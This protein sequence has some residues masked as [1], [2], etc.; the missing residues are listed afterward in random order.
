MSRSRRQ[1]TAG[2]AAGPGGAVA[3]PEGAG[4]PAAARAGAAEAAPRAYGQYCGL[5]RAVELVGDRWAMLILRDLFVGPRRYSDLHNGLPRIPTNVL[6]ARLKA[7][8]AGGVVRR[9]L[10][11]RPA[12]GVVYELTEYGAALEDVVLGLG[13]W[14]AKSLGEIRPGEVVTPDSLVMALRSTFRPAAARGQPTGYE[15]RVGEVTVH[16]RVDDGTVRVAAGPLPDADLTIEAGP[17]IRALMAG[18][19]SPEA[20]VAGGAVRLTGDPALLARFVDTF[21]I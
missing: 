1:R 12:G 19:L 21:R 5:A 11:P 15:L 14:G 7:L 4:G 10:L 3:P 20:A 17:A 18:E 16:A 13:R 2:G 8:E 6:A 9:R